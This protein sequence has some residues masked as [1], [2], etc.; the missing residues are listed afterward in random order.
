[1]TGISLI[2]SYSIF[3]FECK[4]FIR[5]IYFS[6]I[7]C[8][9]NMVIINIDVD[10]LYLRIRIPWKANFQGTGRLTYDT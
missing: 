6:Y 9:Q 4:I 2:R 1:M 3:H 5:D 7:L 8:Y 10:Q